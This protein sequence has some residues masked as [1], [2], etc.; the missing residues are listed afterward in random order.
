MV[1]WRTGANLGFEHGVLQPEL[2]LFR[3]RGGGG[4]AARTAWRFLGEL[5]HGAVLPLELLQLGLEQRVIVP[6]LGCLSR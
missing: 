5:P 6:L 2:L 1:A 3:A 4:A